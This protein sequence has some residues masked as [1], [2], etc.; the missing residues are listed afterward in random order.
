MDYYFVGVMCFLGVGLP[1]FVMQQVIRQYIRREA[2]YLKIIRSLENRL[3]AKDL[4]GFMALESEDHKAQQPAVG[5][6]RDD[7]TEA[8]IAAMKTGEY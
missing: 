2:E 3:S 8:Q 5:F 1:F 4:A 7:A 6:A